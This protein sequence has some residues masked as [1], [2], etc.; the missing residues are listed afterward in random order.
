MYLRS[1]KS[2]VVALTGPTIA[3]SVGQEVVARMNYQP[4]VNSPGLKTS[5]ASH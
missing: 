3:N 1:V 4:S 5:K 2:T